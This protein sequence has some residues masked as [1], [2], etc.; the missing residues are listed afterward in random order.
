MVADVLNENRGTTPEEWEQF[1]TE[2]F[3]TPEDR[4]TNMDDRAVSLC[5]YETWTSTCNDLTVLPFEWLGIMA[6]SIRRRAEI[7]RKR[8]RLRIR[9]RRTPKMP[10]RKVV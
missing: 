2:F 10:L 4:H 9:W 6:D 7:L 1:R 3:G 8:A 5:F